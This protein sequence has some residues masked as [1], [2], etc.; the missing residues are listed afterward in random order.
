MQESVTTAAVF[1]VDARAAPLFQEIE[2]GEDGNGIVGFMGAD[3]CS[4]IEGKDTCYG[5]LQCVEDSSANGMCI[6]LAHLCESGDDIH[7]DEARHQRSRE[8]GAGARNLAD[9]G[10]HARGFF[11]EIV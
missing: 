7:T 3:V 6:S 11:E 5:P 10:H 1:E 2:A 4:I 9:L 8:L